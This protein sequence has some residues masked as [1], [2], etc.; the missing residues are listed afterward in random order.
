MLNTVPFTM[1][2]APPEPFLSASASAV[3]VIFPV[4]VVK[5]PEAVKIILSSASSV[6]DPPAVPAPV[7][8]RDLSPPAVTERSPP[9]L[10]AASVNALLLIKVVLLDVPE[11]F[12]LTA[13]VKEFAVL[14]KVIA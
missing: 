14:S 6:I 9:A 2:T 8:F 7:T 4:V 5:S 3:T 1:V 11:V 10:E 12:K 13:P